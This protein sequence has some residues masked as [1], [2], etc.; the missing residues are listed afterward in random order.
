[1]KA[2]TNGTNTGADLKSISVSQANTIWDDNAAS[3]NY[4]TLEN[5]RKPEVYHQII[6]TKHSFI[7]DWAIPHNELVNPIYE[8]TKDDKFIVDW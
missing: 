7:S 3:I 6:K 5:K 1:M 2:S 4:Y 8:Y